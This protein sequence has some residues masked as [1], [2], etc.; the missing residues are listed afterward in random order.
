MHITLQLLGWHTC[1]NRPCMT[2][3][4]SNLSSGHGLVCGVPF[5]YYFAFK[6]RRAR[7]S[8]V[9]FGGIYIVFC[10]FRPVRVRFGT[11]SGVAKT[12]KKRKIRHLGPLSAVFDASS[13]P[14]AHMRVLYEHFRGGDEERRVSKNV[15]TRPYICGPLR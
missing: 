5:T 2:C 14:Q 9:Q 15:K 12:S 7:R 4:T 1:Q 10:H 11:E 8:W 3:L 6:E 13:R